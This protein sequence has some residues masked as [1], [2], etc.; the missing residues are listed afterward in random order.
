MAATNVQSADVG[1]NSPTSQRG[2]S[3]LWSQIV[4]RGGGEPEMIAPVV[5][6]MVG[7][8]PASPS[9]SS[10]TNARTEGNGGQHNHNY[11]GKHDH[12]R[13]N[14]EWNQHSRSF[15][16]RDTHMQSPRGGYIR[17]SVHTSTPFISP[18][19][20]V[21]VQPFGNNMMYP[22]PTSPMIYVPFAPPESLRAMP[23]V[24]PLAPSMYFVVP[25]PQLH[26]KIVSQIE[27]YFSNENLVKYTY[28][29]KNMD[30]QGWVSASLIAKFKKVN[31]Y[32]SYLTDNVQLILDAMR[33][34]TVVEV[35]G[36]NIRKRYE[37]MKWIM[38]TPDQYS[39]PSSP[40]AVG[41]SPND[42]GLVSQLQTLTKNLN[43]NQIGTVTEAIEVVKMA[44][45]AEWGVVISQRSGETDDC[46]IADLAVDLAT[47]RLKQ[48]RLLVDPKSKKNKIRSK[49][50]PCGARVEPS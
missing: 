40:Q 48:V 42:E 23:F 1:L 10:K 3:S 28:L 29:R 4:R 35:Q 41:R 7:S 49:Q 21:Q 18:Q 6:A 16:N 39:N 32:V 25:D 5:V 13:G 47:V 33:T 19:M 24:T 31:L 8:A 17:P 36:D 20:P 14:Q 43:V 30:E 27:Y 9:R 34:S 44:K 22:D 12:D 45:D 26:A 2:V 37:W 11:G 15:N 50:Y 38:P 46:F